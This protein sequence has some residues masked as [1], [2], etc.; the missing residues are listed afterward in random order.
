MSKPRTDKSARAALKVFV[1]MLSHVNA[2]VYPP[3]IGNAVQSAV[4]RF[5]TVGETIADENPDIQPEM[6]EACHEART[7]GQLRGRFD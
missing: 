2:F 1:A 6:Y 7:A 3:Q 5:V 4:E